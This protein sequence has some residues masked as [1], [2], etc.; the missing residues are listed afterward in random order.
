MKLLSKTVT[1]KPTQPGNVACEISY[2]TSLNGLDKTRLQFQEIKDDIIDAGTRSF[3]ND[4][5]VTWGEPQPG[6]RTEERPEGVLRQF[7]LSGFVDPENGLLLTLLLEGILPSDDA[8]DGMAWYCM[9]YKVSCDGG[10]TS[11]IDDF[12]VQHG[13]KYSPSHPIEYVHVGKNSLMYGAESSI[14]RAQQGHL[15]VATAITPLGPDGN[16]CNPGGGYTYHEVVILFGHWRHDGSIEWGLGPRIAINPALSTRGLLEPTVARFPDGR[17]LMVMRGSNGGSKDPQNQIP[18]R[19]WFCVS[20]DG[21]HTWSEVKPWRYSN[22][23]TFY[24]PSA[25]SQL[26]R[27]SS[28]RYFWFGNIV[29]ENAR[30]N[31]PRYPVVAAEVD[32]ASLMLIKDSVFVVEDFDPAGPPGQHFSNFAIHEDRLSGELIMHMTPFYENDGVPSGDACIYRL[33]I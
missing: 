5:G 26:F 2:Y 8:L 6:M 28:G 15:V 3:S 22:E 21:G 14:V 25:I 24:S 16:L 27:H 11:L 1:N 29:P 9:R 30:G 33:E 10:R 4:N 31:W 7:E 20:H 18:A 19:K 23:E 13:D 32:P 17:I 12:V